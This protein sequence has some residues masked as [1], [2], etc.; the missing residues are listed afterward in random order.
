LTVTDRFAALVQ[1]P[2]ELLPLDEAALLLAAHAESD[3][4]VKKQLDRLDELASRCPAPTVDGVRSLLF[5]ELGLRGNTIDYSDPRNSFLDQ[6]LDR[7]LGIPISLSVITIEIGR[8]VGVPFEGVGMPG[9]FLVRHTGEPSVLLDPFHEGSEVTGGECE[10]LFR[11]LFGED[12]PFSPALLASTGPRHILARMLANLKG[13]YRERSDAAALAW[14][15]R[16]RAFIPGVP[17]TEL[18][19]LA[20]QLVNLGQLGQA[21]DALDELA[22]SASLSPEEEQQVRS[23]A[24]Q[25]RARLN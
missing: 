16:L 17:Q 8:R 1:G 12:V 13:S 10:S 20:R 24:C 14:V 7:G 15:A 4:D 5:D 23:R 11:T 9:H 3:L 2:E 6:V 21:A 25:L 22:S 19:D 18:A